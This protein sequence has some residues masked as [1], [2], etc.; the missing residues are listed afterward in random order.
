[1]CSGLVKMYIVLLEEHT[2]FRQKLQK[3]TWKCDL[4][5]KWNDVAEG[6]GRGVKLLN[7]MIKT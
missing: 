5:K 2:A 1:M 3:F 4:N 6:E 7:Y